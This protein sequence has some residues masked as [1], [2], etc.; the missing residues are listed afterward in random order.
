MLDGFPFSTLLVFVLKSTN[1]FWEIWSNL[2]RVLHIVVKGFFFALCPVSLCFVP[3]LYF[4]IYKRSRANAK[5]ANHV[6]KQSLFC[7]SLI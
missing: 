4:S 1:A 6:D 5:V 2:E 3:L 7:Y